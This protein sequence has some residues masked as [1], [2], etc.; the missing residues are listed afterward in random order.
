MSLTSPCNFEICTLTFLPENI[1]EIRHPLTGKVG[2]C[3]V[4]NDFFRFSLWGWD[5][6]YAV[7]NDCCSRRKSWIEKSIYIQHPS[8]LEQSVAF[9]APKKMP[10]VLFTTD[11]KYKDGR[12][13]LKNYA[14]QAESFA[15]SKRPLTFV[16]FSICAPSIEEFVRIFAHIIECEYIDTYA[17]LPLSAQKALTFYEWNFE[18]A[19]RWASDLMAD[20]SDIEAA[21]FNFYAM[22]EKLSSKRFYKEKFTRSEFAELLIQLNK[23]IQ[24]ILDPKEPGARNLMLEFMHGPWGDDEEKDLILT[25]VTILEQQRFKPILESINEDI[26]FKRA[27]L[28]FL[29]SSVL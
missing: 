3:V 12:Y 18:E 5:A 7:F 15:I 16:P 6:V 23:K 27:L 2:T 14:K 11:V 29:E 10:T 21:E 8:T 24:I 26:H 1:L 13:D 25:N 22:F 20:N 17:E 4:R 19:L 9:I 28:L